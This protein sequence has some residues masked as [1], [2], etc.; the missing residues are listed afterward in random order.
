MT[1]RSVA[2]LCPVEAS[3]SP[4]F[5]CALGLRSD[6]MPTPTLTDN[7]GVYHLSVAKNPVFCPSLRSL[8]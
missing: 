7:H 8:R 6:H 3:E 5:D 1:G 4:A 2:T